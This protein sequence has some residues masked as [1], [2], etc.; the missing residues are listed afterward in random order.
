[1]GTGFSIRG[2]AAR[3][4]KIVA[5]DLWI[6]LTCLSPFGD[7][8]LQGYLT[9]TLYIAALG[10]QAE[11]GDRLILTNKIPRVITFPVLSNSYNLRFRFADIA[12][13]CDIKIWEYSPD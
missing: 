8:L 12:G 3:T 4:S 7:G 5:L 1:L 2:D 13:N 10:G 6:Y 9:Q 11:I